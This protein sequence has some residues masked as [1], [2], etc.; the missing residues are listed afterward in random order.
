V[1][2]VIILSKEA[3]FAVNVAY[4]TDIPNE[5]R[6]AIAVVVDS[7]PIAPLFSR[8]KAVLFHFVDVVNVRIDQNNWRKMI[9]ICYWFVIQTIAIPLEP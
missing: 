7:V 8:R 2:R 6:S 5:F 1:L 3:M 4:H 9:G